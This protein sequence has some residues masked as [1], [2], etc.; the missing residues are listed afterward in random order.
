MT[1]ADTL[2][3]AHAEADAEAARRWLA[4]FAAALAAGEAA[5]LERLFRPDAHWRDLVA[6]TWRVTTVSGAAAV[7]GALLRHGADKQPRTFA[8]D[9]ARTPPRR[10]TRAGAQVIE[11][12]VRFETA[13]ARC[14]G[15]LRLDPPSG[16]TALPRAWTLFTAVDELKGFE[17]L[18]GSRRPRGEAYSRDFRGPNWL[19]RRRAAA[20]YADRDPAVLVVGGGQAGLSIAARLRHLDVDTLVVDREARIGDN[21]RHRY[22]ALTLHNQV[23]VNHLPYMPFPPGFPT[24][25]PKDK[26]AAWFEAYAEAMEINFW[27]G[28]DF[29][30]ARYDDAAGHWIAEVRRDGATRTLRPRHIVLATGAS[31]LPNLPQIAGLSG[32][33]GRV[34]HSSQYADAAPW[35]G[36]PALVIGTGTSGH[37]VA[38]DLHSNG[39]QVTLVQRSPTLVV[40][41]E[42]SAQLPYTIY[43][44]GRALEESDLIAASTP[45]ALFEQ[46]HRLLAAQSRAMDRA[47]HAALERAGFRL[48]TEDETGW[49]FMYLTRGGG[50]YFNVGCSNLIA[51]GRIPVRQFADIERFVADGA[52]MTD[53]SLLRA[54]LVVLATGY[55]GQTAVVERLFGTAVAERIGPIWGFDRATQELRNMYAPTAQRGL[56]FIAGSFAQCRINSKYL[57]LQIKAAEAGLVPAG[58]AAP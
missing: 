41:I 5:P 23:Q 9:P 47:L 45:L 21:W 40:D 58:T 22:H 26:L 48:N 44:E 37:D 15:V 57:A 7:A 19:D 12:F 27:T 46:S 53:G 1:E 29:R 4:A 31:D 24:Y 18:A 55:R 54:D 28:A 13:P 52:R 17:E 3:H 38:Q 6:F 51:E 35:A 33:A 10:V 8:I 11:A 39:A 20:A 2:N 42:P 32:F 16:E 25:L 49:Q 50:Y 56:W 34:L 14:V 30:G 36:R 43:N